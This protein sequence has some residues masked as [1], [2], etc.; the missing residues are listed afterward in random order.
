MEESFLEIPTTW[1]PLLYAVHSLI[2]RSLSPKL[3]ELN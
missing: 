1:C 3:R 2:H